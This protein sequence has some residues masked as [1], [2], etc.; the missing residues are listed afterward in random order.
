MINEFKSLAGATPR[1]LMSLG[2]EPAIGIVEP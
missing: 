2:A 1:E